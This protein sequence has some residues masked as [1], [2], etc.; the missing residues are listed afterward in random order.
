M[1]RGER[2]TAEATSDLQALAGPS[3]NRRRTVIQDLSRVPGGELSHPEK[4]HGEGVFLLCG[5][6]LFRIKTGRIVFLRPGS[7]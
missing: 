4:R 5:L 3:P 7:D 1:N 2:V 6:I